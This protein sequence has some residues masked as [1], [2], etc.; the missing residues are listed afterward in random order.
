MDSFINF[1]YVNIPFWIVLALLVARCI[2]ATKRGLVKEICSLIA[3]F[4]AGISILLIAFAV[5]NYINHEKLIFVVTL[6]LLAIFGMVYKMI[7]G[8]LTT[9]K[10][11][12]SLPVVKLI[13]KICGVVIGIAEVVLVVWIV[14][15]VTMIMDA[16]PIESLILDNINANPIMRILYEYNYLY[17]WIAPFSDKLSAIDIKSMINI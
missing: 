12:A 2:I 13:D 5:R 10:V 15:C 7:D 17:V 3:C 14:Y 1:L 4:A 8:L 16:G 11:I 9:I 6:V